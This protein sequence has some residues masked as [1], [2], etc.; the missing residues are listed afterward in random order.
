MLK[1]LMKKKNKFIPVLFLILLGAC[2]QSE[3]YDKSKFLD[4]LDAPTSTSN[5]GGNP[6][7]PGTTPPV[8]IIPPTIEN[9][10]IS[11]QNRKELFT[12]NNLKDGDVDILWMIDNSGSMDNKQKRLSDSLGIFIDKFLD[13]NINFKMAITTTDGRRIC[14]GRMIGDSEKLTSDYLKLVGK[15]NFMTYFQEVVKVGTS[16]SGVEQGLKTSTTFFDR[17]ASSFLRND[18][19]LAIVEIS[20]EEDQ[21]EKEVINYLD[22]LYAL[23]TSK[24]KVKIYSIITKTMPDDSTLSDSIGNRYML[25]SLETGGTTSEIKDDFSD[26][27]INIGSS[28]V[29][30][31]DSFSLAESPYNNAI[32]VFI[33]NIEVNSGWTY[34]IPTRS[35]KFNNGIIPPQGSVIEVDYQV[36]VPALGAI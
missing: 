20:D 24:G 33:N 17:Y 14:N 28:I 3:F 15:A 26:I 32:K 5:S 12:Q 6:P 30:L 2:K 23:K 11:L 22:Q 31:V 25:A 34:D 13:K 7:S 29:N 27:L 18:A 1:Q 8:V 21:S 10:N 4:S 35:I 9:P 16:G 36:K 19:N